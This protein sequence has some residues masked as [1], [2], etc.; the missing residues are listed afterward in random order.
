MRLGS[1]HEGDIVE[2]DVRGGVFLAL[3]DKV[4]A[5]ELEVRPITNGYGL[6]RL[7][8]PRQVRAHWRRAGRRPEAIATTA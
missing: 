2:C 7:V 6:V 5:G 8:R 3:V 4:D 1:V